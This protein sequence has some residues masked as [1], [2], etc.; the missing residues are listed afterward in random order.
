MNQRELRNKARAIG[1][2]E[3]LLHLSKKS[4]IRAI[5]KAQGQAPCFLSDNRHECVTACEW[6]SQCKRPI[7]EWLR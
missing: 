3:G 2:T 5:Q 1:I 7:A 4:L 6:K